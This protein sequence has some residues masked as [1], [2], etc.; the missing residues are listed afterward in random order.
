[1]GRPLNKK[2]FGNRNI[3][4]NGYEGRETD[5][6]TNTGQPG[7]T[8]NF[9][10]NGDD[11]IGGEGFG[12]FTVTEPGAYLER[13]PAVTIKAPSLPGG[14]T[15][16]AV[17]S[18]V[19]AT[20]AVPNAKGT[21]YQ[22][23]DIIAVV[24]GTNTIAATFRVT[25]LKVISAT[26]DTTGSNTNWDGTEWI[27]WDNNIDSHWIQP[28]ILKGVT[29]D[30]GHH[31]TGYDSGASVYGV[32][33]GGVNYDP[34]P[35]TAQAITATSGID[36]NWVYGNV[37]GPASQDNAPG[38]GDSNAAGG[39]VTF[40]YGIQAVEV[41]EGGDYTG[42]SSGASAVINI[43]EDATGAD[44]TLDV[45]Y[46]VSGFSITNKGSG[47]ISEADALPTFDVAVDGSEVQATATA[48]LTTDSGNGT[49]YNQGNQ[50][51]QENAIIVYAYQD[52]ER[53]IADIVKQT[54]SKRYVCITN[55]IEGGKE[56]ETVYGYLVDHDA[57][58][59]KQIDMKATDANGN[60]YYVTKLTAHKATLTRRT[61]FSDSVTYTGTGY[62]DNNMTGGNGE[63]E[64]L[65]LVSFNGEPGTN[66]D[67]A[68]VTWTATPSV[69]S[70]YT[71]IIDGDT[72]GSG[73]Y[74]YL[75]YY[76]PGAHVY[77]GDHTSPVDM[78]FT[79]P[80]TTAE[81]LFEDGARVEWTFNNDP[82]N[83]QVTIE[84]A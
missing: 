41:V 64:T 14:I 19:M 10:P 62:I 42:V 65:H 40:T 44:A 57:N 4:A 23:G 25:R 39:T 33:N 81:W 76:V 56:D 61:Q 30:G 80:G 16:E 49:G 60:T 52:G 82:D 11:G 51:N 77:L 72:M 2:Y 32:W 34:A 38:T 84:N 31:L 6:D 69:G 59:P 12:G 63:G 35:T 36:P 53:R 83:D 37:R 68:V 20:K 18:H 70:A 47:Y 78:T 8:S 71:T 74:G 45:F 3:G 66:L 29:A 7:E 43:T 5:P 13:I 22:I 27:V 50:N 46:G 15:A 9:F 55:N 54:G 75:T 58:A 79:L 28:T 73:E 67:G 24:G 1:M 26:L 17:V 21:G 48:L